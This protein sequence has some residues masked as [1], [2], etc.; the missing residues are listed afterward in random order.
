MREA[1]A[2]GLPRSPSTI[3]AHRRS[4]LL[5]A[6]SSVAGGY[7]ITKANAP[8]RVAYVDAVSAL[9][10]HAGVTLRLFERYGLSVEDV[11]VETAAQ[12]IHMLR[13]GRCDAAANLVVLEAAAANSEVPD[14]A[15]F[16]ALNGQGAFHP[17]EQFVVPL[18]SPAVTLK[19]LRGARIISVPGASNVAVVRAA[20]RQEN[21]RP[22]VDYQLTEVP[23]ARQLAALASGQCDAAYT[24][25]PLPSVALFRGIARRLETNIIAR[26]ILDQEDV[27]AFVAGAAIHGHA[28][29][30]RIQDA[31][32]FVTAW[33]EAIAVVATNPALRGSVL[34]QRNI[35]IE[36]AQ[37][38]RIPLFRMVRDLTANDLRSLQ[39]FTNFGRREGIIGSRIDILQMLRIL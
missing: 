4:L 12:A 22:S 8:F 32:R 21:L 11:Q 35:P 3:P 13:T 5:G 39:D 33:Q 23:L 26:R 37:H 30:R 10:L 25:E 6:L 24:L 31:R 7:R 15:L 9:P 2:R 20:L 14:T 19:D 36:I 1:S 34:Q 28:L 17:V 16:F 18:A 29:A 38:I 27:E